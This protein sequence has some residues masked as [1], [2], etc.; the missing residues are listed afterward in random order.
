V[1]LGLRPNPPRMV[2]VVIAVAMFAIGLI[3]VLPPLEQFV[4]P[5]NDLLASL[6]VL[7]DLGLT[8]DAQ[9]AHVLLLGAPLLL[10]VGSLL[11][12]I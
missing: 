1:I 12:G 6:P 9:L 7:A 4:A 2:T 3:G 8:L 5:L 10:I 11:R